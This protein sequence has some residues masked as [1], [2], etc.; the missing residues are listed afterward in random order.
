LAVYSNYVYD[1]KIFLIAQQS[2]Y[3]IYTGI[4]FPGTSYTEFRSSVCKYNLQLFAIPLPK[5][6]KGER[7]VEI[8]VRNPFAGWTRPTDG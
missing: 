7:S 1:T 5:V 4:R 3:K 2:L 6:E 8:A